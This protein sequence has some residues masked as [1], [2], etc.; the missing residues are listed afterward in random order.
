MRLDESQLAFCQ[1]DA[2]HIRLLAPAG[3]GKTLALL[4]RCRE[5]ASRA[6]HTPRFLVVTFTKSATHELR[7]RLV[8]DPE[9]QS[10]RDQVTISTLNA[11]GFRR[12]RDQLRHTRLLSSN[13]ERHF[14]MQNQLRPVWLHKHPDVEQVA[15]R[16][17]AG[18]RRLMDVMDALKTLGFDHTTDTNYKRFK[19]RLE[20]I[21]HSWLAPQMELQFDT[22]T[23]LKVLD[24]KAKDDVEA[25][26]DSPRA[27]Y[28]RFF[29]F[30]R[31]ATG[32][33]HE[34]STFTF[35]DQKY[36]CWLDL[37]S[38]DAAGKAKPAVTGIARFDHI[39]VDEFQDINPLDLALTKTLADRHR[40][41]ITIVGDDDQAIF[42]WR[43][44]TPEYILRPGEHF[45][46]PFTTHVLSV[47]YRS[48]ANV[49]E[50]AQLLISNN[51][52]RE[53]KPVS[54]A[55]NASNAEIS[56]LKTESI[57]ERLR[58]VTG[59]ARETPSPGR[60]AVIGRLRSQLIPYEVFYAADGGEVR[61]ATDLD[62]LAGT[63]FDN[64]LHLL[65]IWE[66]GTQSM[67]RTRVADDL[68]KVF[69]LIRRAPFSKKNDDSV[70]Q[71]LNSLNAETTLDAAKGFADYDG[72]KL[73][74]KTHEHLSDAATM[75]L[76]S[77]EAW[78]AVM[79]IAD[80]FDG[81][82]FDYE[83]S[84][85]DV[86][87]TDPPLKQLADMAREEQLNAGDLIERLEAARNQV[88]HFQGFED[89]DDQPAPDDRTL[90]LMT[91]TRA[92]GKEFD[93]VIMLDTGEGI[94]PYKRAKTKMEVEAERRLF[95]VAFTR[96]RKRVV[97]L[98]TENAELS[99]FVF[100]LG[101]PQGDL[102]VSSA[103]APVL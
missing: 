34:Q 36:W 42:E 32:S 75:F 72:T 21:Q 76:N 23:Q 88:K 80:N 9:F 48:P 82:R 8:R 41:S 54:A 12:M 44:A 30:W 61:T 71:F 18:P 14:A 81:L 19:A 24:S 57:G 63:A 26:A 53:P 83:K 99:R 28:D 3:C 60:V 62:A 7:S 43:G 85:D 33:L 31:D 68:I 95:Y 87:Y 46:V 94:W 69:N 64:L 97:M 1:S 74:G 10:I 59:I 4:Y 51:E 5:L 45:G 98:T 93:T 84:E 66:R 2:E 47:N 70:R 38:P 17:G 103:Q 73:S 91:A 40:A 90:Q 27:F 56:V 20:A 13:K 50:H 100:E 86:W 25:V 101:L 22:L 15:D 58:I 78:Q 52:R 11:Y 96:A 77:A 29:R 92:K 39:L 65:E 67:R 37:R 6:S 49:V 89:D 102:P 79:S 55:P 35:E 16:R